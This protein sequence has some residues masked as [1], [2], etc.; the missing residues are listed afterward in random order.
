V[1]GRPLTAV[2]RG[3]VRVPLRIDPEVPPTIAAPHTRRRLKELPKA[4]FAQAVHAL[5][6]NHEDVVTVY[7][8]NR[9]DHIRPVA[10]SVDYASR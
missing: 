10:M 1:S 7:F 2:R 3:F 6:Q 9:A 4:R 8:Y 5:N